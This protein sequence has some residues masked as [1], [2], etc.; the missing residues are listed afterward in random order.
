MNLVLDASAGFEL[1]VNSELGEELQR[2]LPRGVNWW[3][4]EHYY[5]ETASVL[6]R[7][8]MTRALTAAETLD[9]F[10]RLRRSRLSRVAVRPLLPAAWRKRGNLTVADALYVVLAE[11]LDAT[12][13]TG[14][15]RLANAVAGNVPTITP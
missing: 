4:P 7:A 9:A 10:D 8:E 12:L 11:E 6:R 14:D 3:V 2:K 1:L 13:V 5:V 15:L